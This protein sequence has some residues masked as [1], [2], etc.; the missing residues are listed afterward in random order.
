[1]LYL[2][3]FGSGPSSYK[4]V[5]LAEHYGRRGIAVARLNLRVPSFSHLRPSAMIE[6]TRAA[7]G[8]ERDRA[9]L[10]GS[11]LGGLVAS[12]VA[13]RDARVCALVLLAP[14]FQMIERW[15]GRL[16]EA[17]WKAWEESGWIEVKDYVDNRMGRVDFG[18][19]RDVGAGG[20]IRRAGGRGAARGVHGRSGGGGGDRGLARG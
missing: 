15:R 8:G 7:L 13:E 6:T 2:H 5:A 17:G 11:S 12:R 14:A 9:V 18:F 10:F 16:G 19:A 3:G 4:G 1:F 20:A